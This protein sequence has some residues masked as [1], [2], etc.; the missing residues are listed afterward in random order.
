M[1]ARLIR[2]ELADAIAEGV[3]HVHDAAHIAHHSACSHRAKRHD[4]T[5]RIF[6][7]FG[8]HVINHAITIGLAKV[9]IKVGHRDALG[10]QEALKQQLVLQRIKIGN[11]ERIGYE[12]ARTR[13]TPRPH[14]A[15][16]SLGPLNEI[17]H[18][19]EVAGKTHL[20]NGADF[21]L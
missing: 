8:L 12:R 7:V 16:I 18:D 5:H 9:D 6:A 4:L 10:V 1:L 14:R 11:F 21:K 17:A 15:A 2:N 19:Q 20:Q 13:A 3:A